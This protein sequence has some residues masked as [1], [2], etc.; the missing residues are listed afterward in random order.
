MR[1]F[2]T[3]DQFVMDSN[4]LVSITA[5]KD[6]PLPAII[7]F[8]QEGAYLAIAASSGLIEIA[9]RLRLDEFTR[10]LGR[11]QPVEGLQTTRQVGTVHAYLAMGLQSGGELILRPTIAADA[12]GH[13]CFNLML[14]QDVTDSLYAWL[15]VSKA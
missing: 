9:L 5:S 10:L 14:P 3:L 6:T 13:F 12:T 15:E 11:L 7:S 4:G 1:Q 8:Q 2:H